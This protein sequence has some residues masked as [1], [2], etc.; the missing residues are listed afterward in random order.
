MMV[1]IAV[2]THE[3]ASTTRLT[4]LISNALISQSITASHRSH[5]AYLPH[6]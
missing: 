2:I 1:A 6:S 4:W 3:S 5:A